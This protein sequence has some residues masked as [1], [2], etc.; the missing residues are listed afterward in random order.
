MKIPVRCWCHRTGKGS[1]DTII[2]LNKYIVS[3]LLENVKE[4]TINKS[5]GK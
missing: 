4:P 1:Y 5:I 3:Q 2:T